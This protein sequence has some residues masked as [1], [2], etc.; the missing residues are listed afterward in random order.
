LLKI[1]GIGA[2]LGWTLFWTV[3]GLKFGARIFGPP[4]SGRWLTFDPAI[5]E[6]PFWKRIRKYGVVPLAVLATWVASSAVAALLIRSLGFSG[7]RAWALALAADAVAALFF[8][9]SFL[10]ILRLF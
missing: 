10:G 5:Y 1:L 3:M 2:Y 7:R 4:D 9:A 8:V 6:T